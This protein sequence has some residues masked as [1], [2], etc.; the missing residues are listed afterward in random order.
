M[1]RVRSD[2]GEIS[3]QNCEWT[4]HTWGN[5]PGSGWTLRRM[6]KHELTDA[7]GASLLRNIF[8]GFEYDGRFGYRSPDWFLVLLAA[9]AAVAPWIHWSGRFSLRALLIATTLVALVLGLAVY[10]PRK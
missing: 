7:P 6:W 4:Y 10:V 2:E 3:Y 9:M 8:R 1:Y 5:Q